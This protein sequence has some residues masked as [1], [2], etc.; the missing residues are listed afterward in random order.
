MEFDHEDFVISVWSFIK[1]DLSSQSLLETCLDN[2]NMIMK[3]VEEQ[4]ETNIY[5]EL[6][7]IFLRTY[8]KERFIQWFCSATIKYETEITI[9]IIEEI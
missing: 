1:T 8:I 4:L 2:E 5:P 6:I 3:E 7:S 9:R